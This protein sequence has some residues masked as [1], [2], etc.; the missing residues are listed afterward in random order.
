[1][2]LTIRTADPAKE[3]EALAAGFIRAFRLGDPKYVAAY[4]AKSEHVLHGETLVAEDAGVL[5]AQAT[6]AKMTMML[7][8]AEVSCPGITVVACAPE[9][10][11]RGAVDRLMRGLLARMRKRRE[12][13]SALYPFSA[14]FYEKFGYARVDWPEM[15]VVPPTQLRPSD[16]RRHV[17]RLDP[18]KDLPALADCYDRWRAG[19]TGPLVR[20][21]NWWRARVFGKIQDGVVCVRPSRGRGAA[22]GAIDG[23]LF[24][25]TR[26]E[27][28][29]IASDM[30]V[31]EFVAATPDGRSALYGFLHALGE[32]FERIH[33]AFPR[34]E[35]PAALTGRGHAVE[36]ADCAR[37]Q[38]V[39][40]VL[41]GAMLRVVDLRRA[42]ALHPG[43]AR[44]GA[45]GLVGVDLSDPVFADQTASFDLTFGPSGATAV[46]ARKAKARLAMSI[47]AFS[48]VYAGATRARAMWMDG[49]IGGDPDV[50]ALLDE[51]FA[52]PAPFWS[53]LN[54]F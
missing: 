16:L 18:E 15:F 11:R 25:E 51:A 41:A 21:T 20:T 4:Y 24:Y 9:H 49:V 8:G 6:A 31:K 42:L 10:R 30:M 52:G 44:S 2:S 34:G 7:A 45:R 33:V 26:G 39:G 28:N 32:Q 12:P 13:L 43:P 1:M 36:S 50:A 19:R 23:Y 47:G 5:A 27:P 40:Q 17:R 38:I 14:P 54:G 48:Q 37:H 35:G 29:Q 22:G 53:E 46:R 3:S